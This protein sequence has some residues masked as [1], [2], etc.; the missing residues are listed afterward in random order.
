[1]PIISNF[2]IE[3][4]IATFDLNNNEKD[5]K[6]SLANSI[7]R[8]LISEIYTYAIN[9]KKVNFF[10]TTEESNCILNNEFLK[11]R[12]A[13]IPIVSNLNIDYDNIIISCKKENT[14][15]NMMSIYVKDF[16]CKNNHLSSK[17]C[18]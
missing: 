9:E 6:I 14:D 7:R 17:L 4:N 2:K 3:N 10:D 15:E 13:L 1:M 8:I 11:H 18:I 5:I 12:L 16:I